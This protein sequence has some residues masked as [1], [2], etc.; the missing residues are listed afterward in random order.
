ME[1][2]VEPAPKGKGPSGGS[3]DRGVREAAK[4]TSVIWEQP[5]PEEAKATVR[6]GEC[7]VWVHP[8][9]PWDGAGHPHRQCL[10]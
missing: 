8:R 4:S 3:G 10:R 7:T 6:G 5:R 1:G 2:P 9:P